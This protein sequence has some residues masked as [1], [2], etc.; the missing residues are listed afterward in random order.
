MLQYAPEQPFSHFQ[1]QTYRRYFSITLCKQDL[2]GQIAASS[3]RFLLHNTIKEI[4]YSHIPATDF[5][6]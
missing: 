5:L 4:G 1:A 3:V 6:L 2:A